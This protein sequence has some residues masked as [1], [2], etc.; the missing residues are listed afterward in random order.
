MKTPEMETFWVFFFSPVGGIARLGYG[1]F[2]ALF[3]HFAIFFRY[4]GG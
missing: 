2:S 3:C 1:C 4:A